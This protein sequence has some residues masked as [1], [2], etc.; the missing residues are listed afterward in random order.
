M[1]VDVSIVIVCMNNL[2]NLYPCLDSIKQY[3]KCSYEV[4]VVAY[5]FTKENLTQLKKD[6]LWITVIESNV[7]R[8]FSENNNLAL[9]RACGEYCFILN[10]DTFLKSEVVDDLVNSMK[11]LPSNAV[12]M[13]PNILYPNGL[14]QIC[15]RRRYTWLSWILSLMK[16]DRLFLCKS[17]YEDQ[18]GIFET[19]NISGAA[20]LIKTDIFR[21]LGWFDEIYFFCPEDIAL[22]DMINKKGM[23]CYVNSDI[24]LYHIASGTASKVQMATMPAHTMGALI[25]YSNNNIFLRY[26]LALLIF[27]IRG[28]FF[29]FHGMSFLFKRNERAKILCK[30]NYNVCKT[31][32]S[33]KTPK[34]LFVRFYK[35]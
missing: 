27:V 20:F 10:D 16:V 34:E 18:I 33:R 24:K 26:F 19:Y 23:R 13:S 7:I 25:F 29:A 11:L 30:G 1:K 8:G 22:S 2:R 4:L 28:F 35:R 17:E 9:K 5:L 21:E 3:T 12:I 32:F 6:Y 31:I 15:G 14:P